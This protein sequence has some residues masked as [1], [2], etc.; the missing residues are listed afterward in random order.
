MEKEVERE[1]IMLVD[2]WMEGQKASSHKNGY[3]AY[4]IFVKLLSFSSFSF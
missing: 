4:I 2:E 1:K 3:I